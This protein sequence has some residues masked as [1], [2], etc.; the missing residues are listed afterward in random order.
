MNEIRTLLGQLKT[1]ASCK[2]VLLTS[3]GKKFSNGVDF[4]SLLQNTISDRK[5]AASDLA[6]AIK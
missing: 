6:T 4:S 3:A 2:V 1:D 5:R